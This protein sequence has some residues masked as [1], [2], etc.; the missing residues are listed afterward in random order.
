[1]RFLAALP[2]FCLTAWMTVLPSLPAA[3]QGGPASVVTANVIERP[4]TA[5]QVFIANIT[6]HRRTTIGSAV[7][8]RVLEYPINAGEPVTARQPLAKLRTATMEIDLA[9]A[10]AELELR[11]AE[12]RELENGS[13]PEEIGLAEAQLNAAKA[14]SEYAAASFKRSQRLFQEAAG[15]SQDEYEASR[16][17]AMRTTALVAEAEHQLE[18]ARQGPRTE[19]IDQARARVEMQ[20]QVVTSL[21]DRLE[22]FTVRSPFDGIV[23]QELTEEGAWIQQGDAVAEVVEVNPVM[24]E[25]YVPESHIQYV[26]LGEEC[27]IRAEAFPGRTFPG[28]ISHIVPVAD[29]KS[30]SFPVR[31]VVPNEPVNGRHPLLPGMLARVSLA[32]GETQDALLVPKD[33]LQLGGSATMVIK[34]VDGKAVPVPIDTGIAVGGLIQVIP[35]AQGSLSVGDPVVVRGNER[36]RPGQAVKATSSIDPESLLDS[37]SLGN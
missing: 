19:Q 15:L 5:R 35:M 23:S 31:V 33:A 32:T 10:E 16:A 12:L 17:E 2:L 20:R 29:P 14:S 8:G 30:R 37:N 21:E 1:M 28:T 34:I 36:L 13:R 22:K 24:V 11:E 25:V 26:P 4:A 6:P 7:D 27:E 9:A 3:A 18:L